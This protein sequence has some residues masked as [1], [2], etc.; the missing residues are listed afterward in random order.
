MPADT[1]EAS[2]PTPTG[3]LPTTVSKRLDT[4]QLGLTAALGVL[5][6]RVRRR[7]SAMVAGDDDS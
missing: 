5:E 6:D 4:L 1:T 3:I 7:I 2:R